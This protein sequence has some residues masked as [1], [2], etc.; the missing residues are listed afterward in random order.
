MVRR[1]PPTDAKPIQ[2]TG[3]KECGTCLCYDSTGSIVKTK[4]KNTK[5][6]A[7]CYERCIAQGNGQKWQCPGP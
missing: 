5:T 6:I 3:Q 4:W 1:Y 2:E 7:D